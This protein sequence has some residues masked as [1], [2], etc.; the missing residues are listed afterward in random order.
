MRAV[1]QLN[2]Y[3]PEDGQTED[4]PYDPHHDP[5]SV[6][7]GVETEWYAGGGNLHIIDPAVEQVAETIAGNVIIDHEDGMRE[8]EN[9]GLVT[10]YAEV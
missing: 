5:R 9:A 8:V 3:D 1:V 7:N 6:M 10:V 2:D 4:E